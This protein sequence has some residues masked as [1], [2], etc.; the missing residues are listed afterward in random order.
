[1]H[2]ESG[3]SDFQCLSPIRI[4]MLAINEHV[5]MW[6]EPP[7]WYGIQRCARAMHGK[8]LVAGLGLGLIAHALKWNKAVREILIIENNQ[9]VIDLIGP[10]C[11]RSAQIEHADWYR[12]EGR[13]EPD[14]VLMDLADGDY[15]KERVADETEKCRQRFPSAT[16]ISVHGSVESRQNEMS[17]F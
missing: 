2:G 1:M 14:S 9:D 16:T 11:P 6:D 3:F 15:T 13:F 5:S 17:A 4:T 7:H 10:M 12:W 8:V